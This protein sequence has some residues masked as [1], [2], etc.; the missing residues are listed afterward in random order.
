MWL[1]P[2]YSFSLH[3][4]SCFIMSKKH[5]LWTVCSLPKSPLLPWIIYLTSSIRPPPS[6]CAC[7]ILNSL[8]FDVS[9]IWY[10][11]R[12]FLYVPTVICTILPTY[13]LS[14]LHA[15]YP[16]AFHPYLFILYDYCLYAWVCTVPC[17][18]SYLSVTPYLNWFG[19][20]WAVLITIFSTS[21]YLST[22]GELPYSL[23]TKNRLS[24]FIR[25]LCF[26]A[27]LANLF[28]PAKV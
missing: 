28:Y 8:C 16:Y 11:L 4:C 18:C 1:S 14:P 17:H 19:K 24:P 23:R 7:P 22:K 26:L 12:L 15:L 6:F 13:V 9:C 5:T 21:S 25:A 20:T 10:T 2:S 3:I 27:S